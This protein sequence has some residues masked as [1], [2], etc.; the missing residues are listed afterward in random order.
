[1]GIISNIRE[2]FRRRH[3]VRVRFQDAFHTYDGLS[4]EARYT[5]DGLPNGFS[6][7]PVE[8]PAWTDATPGPVTVP[9]PGWLVLNSRGK[10]VSRRFVIEEV[11]AHVEVAPARL[12]IYSG[13]SSKTWDGDPLRC[14][15][16]AVEGLAMGESIAARAVGCLSEPG[17]TPNAIVVDWALSS[18]K[19]GNYQV[20]LFPGTLRIDPV[21]ISG[22]EVTDV[23]VVYDGKPH[24]FEVRAPAGACV[25]FSDPAQYC[26]AGSHEAAFKA[27]MPCHLPFHGIA[28]LTVLPRPLK[29]VAGS[30]SK[31]WDGLPLVCSQF[32][33]E[34]LVPGERLSV[35]TVGG[36]IDEGTAVNSAVVDWGASTARQGNYELEILPGTLEVELADLVVPTSFSREVVYD[37]QVHRPGLD[38]PDGVTLDFDGPIDFIQVGLYQG[39]FTARAA[40]HKPVRGE[41]F[42]TIVDNPVP[43]TVTTTGGSFVYDGQEHRAT[44]EL[45][46]L[47]NGYIV[48]AAASHGVACDVSDGPVIATCDDL[49]IEDLFERDVTD[50]LNLIYHDSTISIT[51]RPVSLRTF[52]AR[53]TFDGKPLTCMEVRV[54]GLVEGQTA[55]PVVCGKQIQVG[56]SIN[57]ARLVFDGT[58]RQD[59][60]RVVQSFG[61][62][63]VDQAEEPV[64]PAL[65]S[66]DCDRAASVQGEAMPGSFVSSE[67]PALEPLERDRAQEVPDAHMLW[68]APLPEPAPA[69]QPKHAQTPTPSPLPEASRPIGKTLL[70]PD[71]TPDIKRDEPEVEW[72]KATVRFSGSVVSPT[73]GTRRH[74]TKTPVEERPDLEELGLGRG[75]VPF[76]RSTTKAHIGDPD[77]TRAIR[78]CEEKANAAI[79]EIRDEYPDALLFQ[80]FGVLGPDLDEVR[81]TVLD[82]FDYGYFRADKRSAL[83]YIH[84]N[85]QNA[86]LIFVACLARE[87]SDADAVWKNIFGVVD[88]GNAANQAVFKKMFLAYLYQR[89]L[90]VFESNE[91]AH[92]YAR[93]AYLHGGFS[94]DVWVVL[95][96]DALVEMAREKAL[97]DDAPGGLVFDCVMMRLPEND[98]RHKRIKE[99]L[100]MAPAQAVCALFEMAWKVVVQA[101]VAGTKSALITNYGL[102]EMA[103]AALVEVLGGRN[104]ASSAQVRHGI[105]FFEKLRL[106]LD[107]QGG[108]RIAW[109]DSVLPSSMSGSRVDVLVNGALVKTCDIARMTTHARLGGG[110]VEVA[111][112]TRYDVELRL[113]APSSQGEFSEVSSLFQSFQNTKP[114]CYEFVRTSQGEYRF[115]EPDERILRVRRIAYLVPVGMRVDGV[116][117]MELSNVVECTGAWGSMRA[118]QFDVEPGAAGNIVDEAS[119]EIVAAWHEDFRVR[120]DRSKV[121]GRVGDVDLYGHVMGVGQTDVALPSIKIEAPEG[122][123]P[124]DVEVRFVRDGQEGLL[125]ATWILDENDRPLELKLNFPQAEQGKGIVRLCVI[126]ARQRAT[127][128]QLLR[129]RFAI[130]PIQGFRITDCKII[131]HQLYGVYGFTATERMKVVQIEGAIEYDGDMLEQGDDAFVQTLLEA[132]T[133][134]VRLSV[135]AGDVIEAELLLAGVKVEIDLDLWRE[136]EKAPLNL[137]TLQGYGMR[138]ATI[139]LATSA[140]R[141]GLLV[142]VRLGRD[143]LLQKLLDKATEAKVCLYDAKDLLKPPAGK[144]YER[145]PLQLFI[146]FGFEL[147]NGK[148]KQALVQYDLLPCAKGLGFSKCEVR[149][150]SDGRERLCFDAD[151]QSKKLACDLH[152]TYTDGSEYNPTVYGQV[153]VRAG[154]RNVAL[155]PEMRQLY[156]DR[157]RHLFATVT[158]LSLFGEPDPDNE[159][160]VPL[161]PRKDRR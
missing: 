39:T 113:M 77:L 5:V 19:E 99:L 44:V 91:A 57:E 30:A 31:A 87:Y 68:P 59:N 125:D 8:L 121:I 46:G 124:D 141:K 16:V 149:S 27:T 53:K 119:G 6:L 52:D 143:K 120:V 22:V 34:G 83:A 104:V 154:E 73:S 70:H 84:D 90:P 116:R 36:I 13:S 146:G 61:K 131:D 4:H 51:P 45:D 12:E 122:T 144:V 21:A 128:S 115:R 160:T 78:H 130:A 138:Q 79:E 29:V 14:A 157:R 1:M 7:H 25:V 63:T 15:D 132:Q 137:A 139:C 151:T 86:F 98:R 69:S 43:V 28:R 58:A 24:G 41:Y 156:R 136:V 106:I 147:D 67:S 50:N 140:A 103:M 129:Y 101:V 118:F 88:V 56:Q 33:V 112:C 71:S 155:S 97:P 93:T 161:C 18:A 37:G 54:N 85:C 65:E 133:A 81:K 3:T 64:M 134:R 17:S 80:A 66:W 108:V 152:V 60:Y 32:E 89:R 49:R 11:P 72:R 158:T 145:S 82:I 117:G 48:K 47:P 148:Y 109:H 74:G 94:R 110:S 105:V 26:E 92:Y 114:A 23:C 55:T 76:S 20:C 159:I 62:L 75:F 42:L 107:A 95:W 100:R 96:R 123:S 35:H 153:T 2:L 135:P 142:Q 111:P 102:S 126:E 127:G 9:S 150:G 38:G 40:H 10:D